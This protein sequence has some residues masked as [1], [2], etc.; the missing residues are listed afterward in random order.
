MDTETMNRQKKKILAL[1]LDAAEPELIEKWMEDGSLP[2]LK[3]LSEQGIY[4]RVDSVAVHL[5]EAIPYTFFSGRAPAS[6]GALGYATWRAEAMK[7]VPPGPDWLPLTPFWRTFTSDGP[8]VIALDVSNM[9]PPTPFN[10]MEVIGWA[11]HDSL[12]PFTTQP[13]ELAEHIHKKYGSALLPDEFYGLLTKKDF[14]ETRTLMTEIIKKFTDLTIELI[15]TE[16]WDFFLG[17]VFTLHHT[18]HRMW[19]TVN[20]TDPLTSDEKSEMDSAMHQVYME[21]DEAVGKIVQ[22]ADPDVM[23]MV[24]SMHGMGI[25]CSRTV[26]LP[27]MLRLISGGQENHSRF[28]SIL[29]KLRMLVPLRWRHALKL[30]MPFSIRRGLTRFWRSGY[31]WKK[32]RAFN[33]LSDTHGWIRINL[34]GREAQGIVEP[35]D[36]EA[37]LDEFSAALK[38]FVDEDTGEPIVKDV[39]CP[40]ELYKGEKLHR[41]PDL[42]IRWSDTP[43]HTHRAI[44][45]P[46]FGRIAWPTPGRNPEGRS[47]NHKPQ[48]FFIAKGPEIAPGEFSNIHI[49]DLAPTILSLLGQPIPPEMEGKVIQ[50]PPRQTN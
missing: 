5:S 41:L 21:A 10:G 37:V 47:G 22:A 35:Q 4:T 24:L 20:V 40:G 32:T 29:R 16:T 31:D 27:D 18:G 2:N 43:A 45:S 7:F 49:L 6:H 38:T 3:R 26:I 19:N 34:K 15:T 39:M 44:I 8:R 17:Y 28:S 23:I 36:Y 12:V 50:F 9:Y 1:V 14:F 25:N 33:L 48:G 11:S 46:Q 30:K 13:P 42:I